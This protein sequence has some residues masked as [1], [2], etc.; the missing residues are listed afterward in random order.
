MPGYQRHEKIAPQIAGSVVV[1]TLRVNWT[2]D[3]NAFEY[4]REGKHYRYGV[5]SR[6]RTELHVSTNAASTGTQRPS[7]ADNRAKR[8]SSDRPARGRQF[9]SVV[10]PDGRFKA[11]YRDRNVWLAETNGTNEVAVT[12]EGSPTNRVKYGTASWAYGEELEQKTA[13]WWSTNSQ[14]LAFYRFDESQGCIKPVSV[15]RRRAVLDDLSEHLL[16]N[17][18]SWADAETATTAEYRRTEPPGATSGP[19]GPAC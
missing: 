4:Q 1:G 18:I 10:S 8:Q 17:P 9:N 3:G 5:L 14:K 15:G 16:L 7:A 6:T 13:I 19:L 11:I 12:V 2:N